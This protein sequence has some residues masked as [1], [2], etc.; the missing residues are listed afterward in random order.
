M[1]G[2]LKL[3]YEQLSYHKILPFV[4]N[5]SIEIS[6]HRAILVKYVL[7]LFERTHP[8][9]A[10]TA[11]PSRQKPVKPCCLCDNFRRNLCQITKSSAQN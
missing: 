4:C 1:P 9:F 3:L 8:N 6:L 5:L 2:L 11:E 7:G 10:I